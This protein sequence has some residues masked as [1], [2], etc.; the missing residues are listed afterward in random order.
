[1]AT[2]YGIPGET[3]PMNHE[4][5]TRRQAIA[6]I[7][8]AVTGLAVPDWSLDAQT[9]PRIFPRPEAYGGWRKG[10]A[11]TLGMNP[12]RLRE[13]VRFHD[14][15]ILTTSYGGALVI[16]YKGYLVNE[17]YTSG[18]EGGPQP[19]TSATCNDMK[20]S[21]KSVFGTAVGVFLDQFK[22]KVTLESLLVG[23]SAKESL[24]PQIWDQPI[25]DPRKM[26]IKIKHAL[27][28]T[29]GHETR[30]PW[31]APSPRVLS[32]GYAASFQM[33]EYCFG[34][35]Q[36]ENIPGQY[37]LRFEPGSTFNYSNFGLEQVALAMR[38]ISKQEV[39]PYLYEKVLR[40]IGMPLSFRT[41]HY[42]DMP[43]TDARELNFDTSAGWG[44]GGGYGCNAYGADGSDSPIGYNNI[45]G[46]TFRCTARDFARLAYL[47]L[48][49]G[50]W[51]QK[52][53]VPGPWMKLAT[54]RFVR[55]NGDTPNNYG[56][57][58]W[59]HKGEPG[60]PE[61]I[62]MS[63]GHNL[64]HSY[65]IPSLDLVVVRQGNDNRRVPGDTPFQTELIQKIVA[66]IS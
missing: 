64:N 8:A 31:L 56:Y 25:T 65:V 48:N 27:S 47:W 17:T 62:F 55:E 5:Q 29:S 63:Q 4:L 1:M 24:I 32:P 44:R 49:E 21:T 42:T 46:S 45:A 14:E 58:F 36:F 66:A 57:T 18:T 59:T 33:Y 20:S 6:G 11:R 40:H 37:A 43:Y 16:I 26:Q 19:W 52:Q 13:A 35:W 28:M 60:V 30:E 34:W 23:P 54:Q 50:R 9:T 2:D 53:L 10:D 39:G 22:S 12:D 3:R 15:S 7:G 61:D 38:N 41:N 51:E